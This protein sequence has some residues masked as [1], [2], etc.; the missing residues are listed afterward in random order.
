MGEQTQIS[1]QECPWPFFENQLLKKIAREI[2]QKKINSKYLLSIYY[3]SS[4]LGNTKAISTW[5]LPSG[6]LQSN[7]R[8]NSETLKPCWGA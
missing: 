3:V 6:S 4:T 2:L 7:L 5:L 1:T 8:N